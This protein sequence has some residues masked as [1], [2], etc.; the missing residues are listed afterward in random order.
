[1]RTNTVKNAS[2]TS[3]LKTDVKSEKHAAKRR[4]VGAEWTLWA[5]SLVRDLAGG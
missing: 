2:N 1:M 3:G 5:K 4:L